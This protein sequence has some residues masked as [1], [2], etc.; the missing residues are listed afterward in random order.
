M[1]HRFGKVKQRE[2][3]GQSVTRK[4]RQLMD[5]HFRKR[6]NVSL[7]EHQDTNQGGECDAVEEDVT[8]NVPFVAVPFRRG[9]GNDD[10]LRVD[11]FTHHAPAAIRRA[12]QYR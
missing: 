10:A 6:E 9:T 4:A 5:D 7:Q 2:R 8:Q 12:H 11:H 1:P 3:K